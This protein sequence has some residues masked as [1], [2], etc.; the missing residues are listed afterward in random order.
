MQTL[1]LATHFNPIYWNTACLIV[2][3]GSLDDSGESTNYKKIAIAI[4]KMKKAGIDISLVDINRSGF[5]FEPDI[6]NNKILFGI[7]AI[8]GVGD[9]LT[10]AIIENRPYS[11]VEDF[12]SKV[13]PNR[14]AMVS[15]IKAG[16]FDNFVD[17][18]KCM[19]DY[20]WDTCDK[21][22]R[23]TLQNLAM[24]MKYNLIPDIFAQEKRVYEFTRY[25]K[26]L[27]KLDKDN[28]KLDDRCIKF[29][30][31]IESDDL[32]VQE[33]GKFVLKAKDW[34][35]VYQFNID[36]FRNYINTHKEELLKTLN[37][38][39]FQEDMNKYAKGNVSAWEMEVLCF[40]YHAHEL[41]NV[42]LEKYGIENFFEL[43]REP[44]V[45]RTY[46][47][48][49]GH[50]GNIFRLSKIAGT[51]IAKDKIRST[52][53]LLTIDGVVDVKF[54]KEYFSL[55]DKQLSEVGPDGSKHVVEKSWFNR[56]QMI[57]VQ[58]FRSE[59]SFIT[60]KYGNNGHQ[61]YRIVNIDDNNDLVI[62]SERY[63]G[64]I[65]ED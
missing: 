49:N 33:N 56:G 57:I 65:E 1:Y 9:D 11:S 25:L 12:L 20:I 17:R 41:V 34:E 14:S 44:E 27:C 39:I 19:H 18:E 63:R 61:L 43:D 22:K 38:I 47:T 30:T 23:L 13:K 42:D 48:K 37:N 51:C 31:E 15:L 6:E 4:G 10:N 54:R 53:S 58:G 26:A 5:G 35:K 62:Q 55:F 29:L 36:S 64:G 28:Y 21:K 60:R 52:V 32:I 16:A 7:K 45:E 2:D 8:V 50:R 59:D 46:T 40:Y 24:L 3:S